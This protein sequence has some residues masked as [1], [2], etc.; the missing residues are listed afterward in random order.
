MFNP[1]GLVGKT[2]YRGGSYAPTRGQNNPQGYIQREQKKLP[3]ERKQGPFGG[4]SNFGSTGLSETRAG[5]AK[6]ALKRQLKH[7]GGN[8]PAREIPLNIPASDSG[9]NNFGDTGGL[10]IRPFMEVGPT[11]TLGLSMKSRDLFQAKKKATE[12]FIAQILSS[13]GMSNGEG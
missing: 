1:A 6:Q 7:Q 9:S 8:T 12:N 2:V 11:G 3:N 10:H 4:V 5:L 13:G